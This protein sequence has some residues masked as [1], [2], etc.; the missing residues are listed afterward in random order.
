MTLSLNTLRLCRQILGQQ[1][2]A[3]SADR[4]EV[5]VV[6]DARDE[7]DAAISEAMSEPPNPVP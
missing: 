6:F 5:E 3:V 4:K 7:L 2:I 1:S